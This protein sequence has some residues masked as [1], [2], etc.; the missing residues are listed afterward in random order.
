MDHSFPSLGDVSILVQS[1][2]TSVLSSL[3]KELYLTHIYRFTLKC[4]GTLATMDP[5][6]AEITL[7]NASTREEIKKD[8]ASTISGTTKAEIK[9]GE[10]TLK[11]K[12]TDTSYHHG[13]QDFCL[14][15]TI[16]G[17]VGGTE[18]SPLLSKISSPFKVYSKKKRSSG[19]TAPVVVE[20]IKSTRMICGLV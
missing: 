4:S 12:F 11:V 8:N 17:S 14:R 1:K 15:I 10:G 18:L 13:K 19:G 9:N 20:T 7:I 2:S 3:P 6:T 16:Y 5:L